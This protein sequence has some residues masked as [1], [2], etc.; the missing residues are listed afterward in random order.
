MNRSRWFSAAPVILTMTWSSLG[1]LVGDV[2]VL[3]RV[4]DR[5]GLALDLL[6]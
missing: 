5:A 6:D 1:C 4:V 3:E 2:D